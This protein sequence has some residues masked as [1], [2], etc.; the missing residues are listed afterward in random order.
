MGEL[1]SQS[2]EFGRF[3]LNTAERVLLRDKD[4]VPLTPKAFDILLALIENSGRLVEKDDLMRKVW[5]NT[6]VEEGNLT[7]NVSLIRKALGESGSGPQF[8]ETV[9]RR[10]YR[11][12]ATVNQVDQNSDQALVP[13][14][15]GL[16]G[17]LKVE[18]ESEPAPSAVKTDEQPTAIPSFVTRRG[19]HASCHSSCC[20]SCHLFQRTRQSDR[21]RFDPVDRRSTV[22]R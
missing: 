13:V 22:C 17:G 11:F 15:E 4:P 2:Y 9:P 5:P 10:G 12:V 6:F 21:G 18:S 16:N 8:I 14:A 7:Q 20:G 3:S 1:S 19:I